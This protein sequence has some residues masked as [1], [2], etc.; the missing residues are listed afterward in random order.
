MIRA[1]IFDFNGVLVDDEPLHYELFAQVL[2]EEGVKLA[3]AD[4]YRHYIG[5]DDRGCFQA[6]LA[7]AGRPSDPLLLMRLITRKATYYRERIRAEGYPFFAGACALV[8]SAAQAGLPLCVVSGALREEVEGAL[9]QAG[10]SEH[11][12]ALITAEDVQ[13]GK[14]D[15]EGYQRAL[16]ALNSRPPLPDRLIH[17]HEALAIEDT[18]AGLAAAAAAGLSTAGVAQTHPA[19]ALAEADLVV[20][21]LARAELRDLLQPFASDS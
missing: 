12:K 4:Y 19:S 6:A 21:S 7:Q 14:P 8:K 2:G 20:G 3:E 15:P 13:A 17:P 1:L 9:V 11:F 18:P 10:V 16:E 5:F